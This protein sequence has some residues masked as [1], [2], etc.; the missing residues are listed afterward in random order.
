V[1][2]VADEGVDQQ[3][4]AR[5]REEGHSVWYIVETGPGALDE[6]VLE[7]ANRKGAILLT[8]DKDFGEMVFRQRR[9]TEGVIFIRLAGQSQ[10]RKAEIAVSTIKRHGEE[11][12]RA[13][14]VITPG[15][16]RIRKPIDSPTILK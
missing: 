7:L 12:F 4:V 5:L 16:I 1:N 13:F 14:S 3:I 10:N 2:F 6:D 8:A 9:L 11:L 15:G